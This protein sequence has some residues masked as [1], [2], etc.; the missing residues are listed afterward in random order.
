VRWKHTHDKTE[1]ELELELELEQA[2]RSSLLLFFP[3]LSDLRIVRIFRIPFQPPI[4]SIP[5]QLP[6]C[7]IPLRPLICCIALRLLIRS[8]PIVCCSLSS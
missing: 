3:C 7:S 2:P 4:C 5:F 1:L 8:A 6:I